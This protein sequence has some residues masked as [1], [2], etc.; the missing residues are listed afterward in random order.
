[1][2]EETV[3][4]AEYFKYYSPRC[5]FTG[6]VLSK[7]NESFLLVSSPFDR[8]VR[9]CT[10]CLVAVESNLNCRS[11]FGLR[12]GILDNRKVWLPDLFLE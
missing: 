7:N 6:S 1:M 5:N 11:M 2:P 9:P 8:D 10:G 12:E 4:L 3:H